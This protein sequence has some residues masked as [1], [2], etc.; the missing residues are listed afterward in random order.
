MDVAEDF[1]RVGGPDSERDDA[2]RR[3]EPAVLDILER[4]GVC[5]FVTGSFAYGRV[6]AEPNEVPSAVLFYRK[7]AREAEVA[8]RAIPYDPGA[9]PVA[10]NFDWSTNFYPL[11]YHRPGPEMVVYRLTGGACAA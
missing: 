1:C 2:A 7:L 8:Y 9:G 3:L 10:F 11:A 4:E 6:Y 5:W